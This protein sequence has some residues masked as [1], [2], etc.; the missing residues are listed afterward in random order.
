[1]LASEDWGLIAEPHLAL[2]LGR[3]V[4]NHL[5]AGADGPESGF[6]HLMSPVDEKSS[7][8]DCLGM[9]KKSQ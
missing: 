3:G 1:M 7:N 5:V 9:V 2:V 4:A 6:L 8:C